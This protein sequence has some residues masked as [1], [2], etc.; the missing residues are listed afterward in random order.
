MAVA[1]SPLLDQDSWDYLI[2]FTWTLEGKV[3]HMYN[4][5]RT[6]AEPNDVSAGIGLALHSQ[7]TALQYKDLFYSGSPGHAPSD[8]E[9]IDDWTAA[10]DLLRTDRNLESTPDGKGYADVCKLRM[11]ED[12][13]IDQMA[14]IL[15][16]KL[17]GEVTQHLTTALF[18][19][20]PAQAKVAVASYLY[21]WSLAKAPNFKKCLLAKD[22]TGAA[23]QCK[24]NGWS[25]AKNLGHKRLLD[26]AAS[27]ASCLTSS[28]PDW[29]RLP[30]KVNPPEFMLFSSTTI[31]RP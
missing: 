18:A 19:T 12:K 26:N 4:N 16:S 8:Q 5:K 29:D 13:V 6:L 21:G 27:I 22:F 30:Q 9:L 17:Q 10:R 28:D 3:L 24:I 23:G 20:F 2:R 15:K 11:N 14:E 1:K 25:P 31:A 7:Q